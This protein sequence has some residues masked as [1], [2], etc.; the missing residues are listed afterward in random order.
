M[1]SRSNPPENDAAESWLSD[2]QPRFCVRKG[3]IKGLMVWDQEKKRPAMFNGQPAIG[4][5]EW[6]A[7][8]IKAQLT[9]Y[10]AK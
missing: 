6:Q 7:N 2:Q 8:E 9:K 4:L 10:Y 3:S 1:T 5:T